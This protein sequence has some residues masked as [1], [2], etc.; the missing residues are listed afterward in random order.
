[1]GTPYGAPGNDDSP[2]YPGVARTGDGSAQTVPARFGA[3][4]VEGRPLEL[5]GLLRACDWRPA[6]VEGRSPHGQDAPVLDRQSRARLDV[7]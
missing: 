6:D 2:P 4:G 7:R 3:Q 5:D 1:M